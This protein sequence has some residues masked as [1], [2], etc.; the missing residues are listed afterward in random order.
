MISALI[1][2]LYGLFLIGFGAFS[3]Y[4][5]RRIIDMRFEGDKSL[6]AVRIYFFTVGIIMSVTL[7]LLLVNNW[8]I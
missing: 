2:S 1:F 8:L 4:F 7:I 6:W 5:T 3:W